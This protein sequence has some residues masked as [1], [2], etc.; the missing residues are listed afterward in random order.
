MISET[1]ATKQVMDTL[2]GEQVMCII[3]KRKA[4]ATYEWLSSLEDI[5]Y[6]NDQDAS[7]G[8]VI[9]ENLAE[10]GREIILASPENHYQYIS[11]LEERHQYTRH[12]FQI[13]MGLILGYTIESCLE[14][15]ANPVECSC[16]KCGG[17]ETQS[18]KL[19]REKW[20][21]LGSNYY[22]CNSRLVWAGGV[23]EGKGPDTVDEEGLTFNMI[24]KDGEP[25]CRQYHV[26]EPAVR[27]NPALQPWS[28]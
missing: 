10:E 8:L 27:N 7:E 15:A 3:E 6:F 9:Y 20:V 22:D 4:P 11:L 1:T 12:G 19:L 13:E 18:D 26:H 24:Y 2:A 5:D 23:V 14:F 16:S 17:P 28:V 25:Y 21:R